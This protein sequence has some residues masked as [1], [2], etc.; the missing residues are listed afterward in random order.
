MTI[1]DWTYRQSLA[2]SL[3]QRVATFDSI[4]GLSDRANVLDRPVVSFCAQ[5]LVATSHGLRRAH[6]NVGDAIAARLSHAVLSSAS[7]MRMLA[8]HRVAVSQAEW[9]VRLAA[10]RLDDDQAQDH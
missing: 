7:F 10:I 6:F 5:A 9:M 4:E 2:C 1:P 3:G 8:V